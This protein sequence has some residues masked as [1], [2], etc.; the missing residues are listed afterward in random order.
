MIAESRAE[1]DERLGAERGVTDAATDRAAAAALRALDALIA[2]DRILA[3]LRLTTFRE[4]ADRTLAHE[5]SES[6]ARESS[7]AVERYV[8]DEGKR[9]EREITDALLESERQR[10][11]A[12][13]HADRQERTAERLRIEGLRNLTDDGISN[14]RTGT[15]DLLDEATSALA[16][17]RTEQ[18]HRREVLGMVTHDLRNS[19]C[20]IALN[21][22]SIVDISTEPSVR[23]AA[24]DVTRAA[25]RMGGS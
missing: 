8:A 2:R 22:Q 11:D 13:L 3:D 17:A 1:T 4:T 25:A 24:Q 7:V 23:E 16:D 12:D 18:T 9:A 14:E 6:G 5:R 20:V 19:L 15:D 21:A 10:S